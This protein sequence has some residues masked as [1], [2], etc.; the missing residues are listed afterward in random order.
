MPWP[1]GCAP[2]AR[3]R[4]P[5]VF[6]IAFELF[7]V[8]LGL[9]VFLLALSGG[10]RGLRARMQSQSRRGRRAAGLVLAP[11]FV[12]FGIAIPAVVLLT[13]RNDKDKEGPAGLELTSAQAD[14]R[15][16]FAQQCSTCHTLR[17]AAAVGTVGPSL[18]TLRPPKAL[19]LD[20]IAKGR[21]QGNGSMPSQLLDGKDARDVADFVAAVAG[22]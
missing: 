11:M 2:A 13:D 8:V 7:W 4:F 22:R 20:A 15:K 18:D 17:A 14:G 16:L 9:A 1:S 10:P 3:D 12:V 6:G 21:A 19:V 5:R